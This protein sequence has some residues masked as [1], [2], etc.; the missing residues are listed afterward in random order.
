MEL[1]QKLSVDAKRA[2]SPRARRSPPSPPTR[3][4]KQGAAGLRPGG[5]LQGP[6]FKELQQTTS[7]S[8]TIWRPLMFSPRLP[9]RSANMLQARALSG[10]TPRQT[11]RNCHRGAPWRIA[12]PSCPSPARRF[13]SLRQ[14]PETIANQ[15]C[16]VGHRTEARPRSDQEVWGARETAD[17]P[18]CHQ[19]VFSPSLT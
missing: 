4:P 13:A 18:L 6:G 12:C 5:F 7:C 16:D 1:Q 2:R 8:A 11:A 10:R 3:P 17:W 9:L 15:E 14:C 19:P